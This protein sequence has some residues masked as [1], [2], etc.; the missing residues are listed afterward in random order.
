MLLLNNVLCL[1]AS[2]GFC[3]ISFKTY[4]YAMFFYICCVT[5]S[6]SFVLPMGYS[7]ESRG[8]DEGE[9]ET[10][11]LPTTIDDSKLLE[12]SS[13]FQSFW[14]YKR[15]PRGPKSRTLDLTVKTPTNP[16]R[17]IK[18]VDPV[19]S[20]TINRRQSIVSSG[21]MRLGEGNDISPSPGKMLR[22]QKEI[23]ETTEKL[24]TNKSDSLGKRGKLSS[25]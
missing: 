9:G 10:S 25:R 19:F 20:E 2:H 11:I 22:L 13:V 16:H 6:F 1:T 8:N 14:V 15:F 21:A 4:Y 17:P 23:L 18:F 5:I 12:E 3:F 7:G 24:S